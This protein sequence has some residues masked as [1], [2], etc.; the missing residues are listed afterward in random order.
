VGHA[1]ATYGVRPVVVV[2]A[3]VSAAACLAVALVPGGWAVVA[4][5]P[6]IGVANAL[7]VNPLLAAL[8]A[9][10]DETAQ[11]PTQLAN[12]GVQRAGA[13]VAA[14]AV[15]L[16][17]TRNGGT[18]LFVVCAAVFVAI[19][20][21]AGRVGDLAGPVP[22]DVVTTYRRS[23]HLLRMS[24]E[25]QR[26]A[27][28]NVVITTFV[29]TGGSFV[30]LQMG[31][32]GA[33]SLAVGLVLAAR[34]VVAMATAA[35]AG[36]LGRQLSVLPFVVVAGVVGSVALMGCRLSSAPWFL[37]CAFAAQGA[38]L[39][40]CI[41]ATNLHTVWGTQAG[42]RLYG[43]AATSFA[44]RV[45]GILVPVVLGTVLG[46][47]GAPVAVLAGG[48]LALVGILAYGLLARGQREPAKSL[49]R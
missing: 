46:R 34:E 5:A 40:A 31:A 30:P 6:V 8:A 18:G 45:A 4:A 47:F 29:V 25:V 33:S 16:L 38:A 14:G 3:L 17:L 19:A 15:S 27:L 32:V 7:L 39:C 20:A 21:G 37:A 13:L 28:M 23:L 49:P 43:F 2:G 42:E 35:V 44:N 1:I 9:S 26:A 41:A 48:A 12:A 24:R 10:A 36:R 22:P 11:V